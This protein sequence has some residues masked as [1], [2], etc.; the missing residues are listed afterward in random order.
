MLVTK[1]SKIKNI[2]EPVE[3]AAKAEVTLRDHPVVPEGSGEDTVAGSMVVGGTIDHVAKAKSAMQT[4][5]E[6]VPLVRCS[7]IYLFLYLS[8]SPGTIDQFGSRQR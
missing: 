2:A 3:K 6:E 8:A 7:F 5:E 1:R 4:L